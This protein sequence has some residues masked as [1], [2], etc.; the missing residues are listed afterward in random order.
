M[1]GHRVL[2]TTPPRVEDERLLRG[3]GR[4]LDDIE[5]PRALHLVAPHLGHGVTAQGCAPDLVARFIR[6]AAMPGRA[7]FTGIED[8]KDAGCL[9]RLPAPMAF[10]PP[11]AASPGASR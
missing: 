1:T 4:F 5:V 3:Q 8:G 2:G 6:Q 9:A 7:P 11:A 10:Q